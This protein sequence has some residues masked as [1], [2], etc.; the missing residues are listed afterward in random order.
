M[1]PILLLTHSLVRYFIL[2]FLIWVIIKSFSAW[3]SANGFTSAD[4][5][6]G[7][8]L[9]ILSHVQLLLGFGLYATS[10][11]V[12]FSPETMKNAVLRYWTVEHIF[13]MIIAIALITIGRISSKKVSDVQV[14]GERLFWFNF[15][16]LLLIV[17]AILLS[18]R[19]FFTL[20][21]A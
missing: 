13:M 21:T 19:G 11:L 17:V 18:D 16:A 20:R 9:L 2:I 5:K 10:G 15:A 8:W 14:K 12:Q 7:V 1:Y 4:E 3:R 6:A